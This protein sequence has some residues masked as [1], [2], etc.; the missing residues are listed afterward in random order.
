MKKGTYQIKMKTENNGWKMEEVNGLVSENFGIQKIDNERCQSWKVTHLLTG[1]AIG[2]WDYLREAKEFV[3]RLE[4]KTD[5]PVAWN[6]STHG[7]DYKP[8]SEDAL[9]IRNDLRSE[10]MQGVLFR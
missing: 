3:R 2:A 1:L 6:S 5:W 10:I 8:N 7:Q 4:E 9:R